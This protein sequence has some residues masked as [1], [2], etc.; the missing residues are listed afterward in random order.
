MR[1][2]SKHV[3]DWDWTFHYA[4]SRIILP[5]NL[6]NSPEIRFVKDSKNNVT[7]FD[8]RI[9]TSGDKAPE[10]YC[11]SIA[12]K[13]VQMLSVTSITRIA[14]HLTGYEGMTRA[15]GRL[16]RTSKRTIIIYN[17]EGEPVK[18]DRLKL[19]D[20]NTQSLMT[21]TNKSNNLEQLSN[22]VSHLC[23]G[24]PG[25]SIIEASKI[26]E[27]NTK[28]VKGYR[29][30]RC[31]RNILMHKKLLPRVIRDFNTYFRTNE[32]DFKRYEPNNNIIILDPSSTTTQQS[33]EK[34]A[35]DLIREV[36]SFLKL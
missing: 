31:I 35:R 18:T 25:D 33:L 12:R 19:T 22:A 30:Y 34:V 28:S 4:L 11:N 2:L 24:R 36:K 17:I 26:I 29:K 13:I 14:T 8:I 20:T 10:D 5:S 6:S 32:F 1:S 16:G 27:G 9:D 21:S 23:D 3:S 7:G 15:H